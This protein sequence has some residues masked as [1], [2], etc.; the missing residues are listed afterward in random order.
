[1]SKKAKAVVVTALAGTMLGGGCLGGL[2]WKQLLIGAA[3]NQGFEY[4]LDND[5][6]F[7]LWEDGGVAAT[8]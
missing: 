2:P 1:M 4:L 8:E 7:D 3:V 5:A 6:V